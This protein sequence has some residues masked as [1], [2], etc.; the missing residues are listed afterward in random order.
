MDFT[1]SENLE[2]IQNVARDFAEKYVR[3]E[4]MRWDEEQFFPVEI[5]K[6]AGELGLMGVLVPEQYGGTG[7]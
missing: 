2:M 5:F 7:L 6:K 4:M 3:P 1:I